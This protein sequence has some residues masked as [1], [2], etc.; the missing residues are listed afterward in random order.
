MAEADGVERVRPDVPP[1]RSL[2]FVP[3]HRRRWVGPARASGAD[4]VLFDL[5]DAVPASELRTARR[6]VAAAIG[7]WSPDDQRILVRVAPP[8]TDRIRADLEAVV[9]AGLCAV[10]LP[11]VREPAE[12]AA[13]GRLLDRIEAARDLPPGRIAVFPLVETALAARFAFEVASASP[14]VE[15]MGAGT[16]RQGDIAR[17]LGYRWTAQGDE[18]LMLR[19]WVLLNARAAG[20]RFPVTGVWGQVDDLD[21]CRRWAEQSRGLGYTGAMVIHPSHVPVVNA[22]F[23]PSGEEVAH[24]RAVIAHVRRHQAVGVGAVRMGDVMVDEADVQTALA[25]LALAERLGVD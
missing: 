1:L 24:W 19:S 18:T 15:Y 20:I 3:G 2:L 8:G 6:V 4:A 11:M 9:A 22:A 17:A 10:V 13:V 12:V 16:S 25:G 14:R 7:Q 21:G 23:T 5:Q